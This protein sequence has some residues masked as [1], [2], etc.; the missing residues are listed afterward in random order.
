[1]YNS[2]QSFRDHTSLQHPV[3]CS[4]YDMS[5]NGYHITLMNGDVTKRDW[6]LMDTFHV[7]R[8]GMYL[9]NPRSLFIFTGFM[10]DLIIIVQQQIA[11]C[12]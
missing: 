10:N 12:F 8:S 3:A 5:R 6:H 7:A 11:G 2:S 4:L 1:M 9:K